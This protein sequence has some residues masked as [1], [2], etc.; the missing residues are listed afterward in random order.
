MA[1]VPGFLWSIDAGT[2]APADPWGSMALDWL[3]ATGELA[4]LAEDPSRPSAEPSGPLPR[5]NVVR[6]QDASGQRVIYSVADWTLIDARF[7]DDGARLAVQMMAPANPD[8]PPEAPIPARWVAIDRAGQVAEL[9]TIEGYSQLRS[10]PGGYVLLQGS[11]AGDGSSAYT[12]DFVNAADGAITTLWAQT[13]AADQP[14]AW[15]LAWTL[16]SSA[17]NVLPAFAGQ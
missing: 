5:Y 3:P 7:I 10:A 6:F 9:Q 2:L 17:Q 4:W 1:S 14:S 12:L 11:R 8:R 16:P 15:E 13:A